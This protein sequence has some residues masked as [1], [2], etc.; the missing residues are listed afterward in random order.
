MS[1]IIQAITT[2]TARLRLNISFTHQ[3][4]ALDLVYNSFKSLQFA[5]AQMHRRPAYKV[6]MYIAHLAG[7]TTLME[8]LT[9]L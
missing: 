2:Q 5:L 3:I 6:G 8:K 9:T 7:T 4:T 1:Q